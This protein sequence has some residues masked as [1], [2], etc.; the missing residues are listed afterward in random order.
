[1]HLR[2]PA[3]AAL[4]AL[5]AV[6]ALG[7]GCAARRPLLD[8]RR[9]SP[10]AER[11]ARARA[12]PQERRRVDVPVPGAAPVEVAYY[13]VRAPAGAAHPVLLL[14]PGVLANASTWRFLAP[15]LAER[16]DL[17]LID[18][19][20]TGASE[21]PEARLLSRDAYSPTWLAGATLA[22]L[23]HFDAAESTPR[24]YVGV[25]HS[26]G[27]AVLLRALADPHL[28]A[29]HAALLARV[30]RLVLLAPADVGLTAVDPRLLRV[31][32]LSDV[33]V[34]LGG[35]LGL[36]R[37]QAEEATYESVLEPRRTALSGEAERLGGVLSR[38]DTRHAAQAMLRRFQPS[39]RCGRPD[40]VA[41]QRL[42]E[43]EA[44]LALPVLLLWGD[45][46]DTLPLA[47]SKDLLERLRGARL[48]VL[49]G[50][51]SLHQER[52]ADVAQRLLSFVG[53]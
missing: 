11:L 46:D 40:A 17:L 52:S 12:Q 9:T 42:K 19:P 50:K 8:E 7:P 18:P 20:G 34:A 2:A 15:L 4:L 23:Q 51:H 38:A 28:Q 27:G 31:R 29:R 5:L 49:P 16:H 14:Q 53:G 10:F 32:D 35:L 21:R 33:E 26:L 3:P 24:R 25:G 44:R 36:V 39:D 6:V 41:I 48:E 47:S 37:S 45:R 43:E 22:A 13:V 30:E 1:M